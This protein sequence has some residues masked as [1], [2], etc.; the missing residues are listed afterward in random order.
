LVLAGVG[1]FIPVQAAGAATGSQLLSSG[2]AVEPVDA[3]PADNWT[4]S[5]HIYSGA[6]G[7]KSSQFSVMP[8]S[9]ASTSTF[10][11]SVCAGSYTDSR[12][13]GTDVY[14][15]GP[16]TSANN[17]IGTPY[18]AYVVH[19]GGSLGADFSQVIGGMTNRASAQAFCR[20][21]TSVTPG[22]ALTT[23]TNVVFNV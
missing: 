18:E 5:F 7:K 1:A 9:N 13:G 4:I 23:G 16:V 11:G 10:A 20:S 19:K 2:T 21:I 17:T 6:S 22:F 12:L 8:G 3:L 14:A 15:V